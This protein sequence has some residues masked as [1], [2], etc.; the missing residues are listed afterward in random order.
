MCIVSY[1]YIAMVIREMSKMP[2]KKYV[3]GIEKQ[4]KKKGN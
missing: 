2:F 3:S 1:I 4:K